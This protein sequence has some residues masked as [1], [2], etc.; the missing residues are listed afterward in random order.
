MEL[1]PGW[2]GYGGKER[3]DHPDTPARQA[4]VDSVQATAADRFTKQHELMPFAECLPA[5]FR[6]RNGRLSEEL[7]S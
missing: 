1:P 5:P 6:G 4:K 3:I 7:E 2:R